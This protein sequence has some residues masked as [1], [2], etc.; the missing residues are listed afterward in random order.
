MAVVSGLALALLLWPPQEEGNVVLRE[1]AAFARALTMELGFTNLSEFQ[2]DQS[3][4]KA[5]NAQDRSFLL[6]ARCDV[7]KESA[8]RALETPLRLQTLAQAASAYREFLGNNPDPDLAFEARTSLADVAYQYGSALK[9]ALDTGLIAADRQAEERKTAETLF[10]GALQA[11]NEV[12]SEYE[13]L[14]AETQEPLTYTVYFPSRFYRAL[15]YYYWGLLYPTGSVDRKENNRRAREQLE[16][17]TLDVGELSPAGFRGYNALAAAY[18]ADGDLSSAEAYWQHVIDNCAAA[19]LAEQVSEAE[20]D[21]RR[22][23]VQ[24]AFLGKAEAYLRHGRLADVQSLGQAFAAWETQ[25]N[26]ILNESGHRVLLRYAQGLN[27]SSRY[28]EALKLTERVARE[29]ERSAL[30]LEANEVNRAILDKLPPDANIDLAV[31]YDA[32]YGA[33]AQKDYP[34]AIQGFQRVLGRLGGSAKADAFGGK[35]YY[36]LGRAWENLER[37]LEAAACY[38]MGAESFGAEDE[39]AEQNG[40]SWNRLAEQF[41]TA[42]RNDKDLAAFR[43]ASLDFLASLGGG[44]GENPKW[45]AANNDFNA[46]RDLE[47]K[48][49]DKPADSTEARAALAAFDK[50]GKGFDG[51]QKG[52]PFYER[53]WVMRGRCEYYKMSWD[54]AAA[55]RAFK[56]FAD[57]LDVYCT[58]VENNPTD[59]AGR[60]KRT[61]AVAD[62]TYW[63]AQVRYKQAELGNTAMY[64][65]YLKLSASY[66]AE[67]KEQKDLV[68]ATYMSRMTAQLALGQVEL[69]EAEF[70]QL[71]A[72]QMEAK[73]TENSAFRLY[74][75]FD[76]Q[77]AAA[78]DAATRQPLARKAVEYLQISNSSAAAPDW[79]NR[80]NEARLW[81]QL[82]TPAP[83]AALLEGI[84]R[85]DGAAL[86]EGRRFLVE[87]ALVDAYLAQDNTAAADPLIAKMIADPKRKSDPDVMDA[88][89]RTM[90]GYVSWRDGKLVEVPGSGGSA[91][92]FR[93]ADETLFAIQNA[94]DYRA[95]ERQLSKFELPEY[96]RSKLQQAYLYYR[97]S[98]VDANFRGKH[99][100][101]IDSLRKL[102]PDLG[103]SVLGPEFQR[104]ME[105]VENLQ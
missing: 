34:A 64:G 23:I 55:E 41:Y 52:S 12:V 102:A 16:T 83:A 4:A 92:D 50:A 99:R 62:A 72:A 28:D 103:A 51:F 89:V 59:A 38:Q 47:R 2:L 14:D 44:G 69:A 1:D 98:S 10:D 105:A 31:L 8:A 79:S 97:W 9:L 21:L 25:N 37:K 73:W 101:L 40:R 3:L 80:Y 68:G 84:L 33:F 87:L 19:D 95:K 78:D 5:K 22:G 32:A 13:Q 29:N 77:L 96:W 88:S 46:A 76:K 70:Q 71:R 54:S 42:N 61:E 17:F 36:Y 26:A 93:K 81:L 67:H 15:I 18:E 91:E 27:L 45:Q 60:R 86:D 11:I 39:Y 49:K 82:N 63:R 85:Q 90:V 30:R 104:T 20:M 75:H 7:R 100:S 94:I 6:L 56:T 57:Y 66:A 35:T 24:D 74:R 53:A 58:N 65:E 48:A 43:Q